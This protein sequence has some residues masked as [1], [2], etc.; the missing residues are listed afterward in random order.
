MPLV[1]KPPQPTGQPI[2]SPAEI[3]TGL[4]SASADDRWAAAR[5]AAALPDSAAALAAALPQEADSRVRE[6]MFTSLVRIGTRDSVAMILPMLR[7]NDSALR[8][9][10]LDALQASVFAAR[11]LLPQLLSDPDADVRILSCELARGLPSEEASRSLCALLARESAVNVC[12]AAIEVLAEVGDQAALPMLTQCGQRFSH[13]PFLSF[14]I[15][16]AMDRI[17]AE[18]DRG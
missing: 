2:R 1:R 12:G 15:K 16:L 18:G 6:A 17:R 10:A 4:G 11:E 8:M 7:S 13:V 14:A 9:G 3:L 5:A